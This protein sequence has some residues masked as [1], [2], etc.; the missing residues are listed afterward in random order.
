M[1]RR[2]NL[3]KWALLALLVY[4]LATSALWGVLPQRALNFLH[5]HMD[6]LRFIRNWFDPRLLFVPLYAVLLPFWFVMYRGKRFGR[7]PVLYIHAVLIILE[8]TLLL[9]HLATMFRLSAYDALGTE[10][11]CALYGT[12]YSVCVIALVLRWYPSHNIRS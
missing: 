2:N 10:A 1:E 5:P 3:I 6:L 12:A 11:L 4:G 9:F 7:W 8:A